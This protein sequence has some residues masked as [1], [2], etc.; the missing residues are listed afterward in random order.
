MNKGW[1]DESRVVEDE[2]ERE[3]ESREV[4]I[5]SIL[6]GRSIAKKSERKKL[7]ICRPSE[8]ELDSNS[9]TIGFPQTRFHQHS[10]PTSRNKRKVNIYLW[11]S[12]FSRSDQMSHGQDQSKQYTSTSHRYVC[13]T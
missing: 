3:R 2:E 13:D 1:I 9:N 6:E 8:Q 5:V 10:T 4:G 11:I 7:S 12:Q